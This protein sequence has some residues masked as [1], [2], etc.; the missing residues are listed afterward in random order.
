MIKKMKKKKMAYKN[1]ITG[2]YIITNIIDN[3]VYIG[4]S[5]NCSERIC[6]H[7][8]NLR[9][10]THANPHLQSSWSLYGEINFTFGILEECIKEDL[11]KAEDLWCIKLNAHDRNFGYNINPTG[12]GEKITK[13]KETIEKIRI[14]NTG[15]T[16]SDETKKKLSIINTGNIIT[17]ETIEKLK[18]SKKN[19][20]VD[21]Y[22]KIGNF[23]ATYKSLREAEREIGIS[24]KG[25]RLCLSSKY[26][27]TEGFIFKYHGEE[28]TIEEINRRNENCFGAKKTSVIGYTLDGVL[29]G[30]FDSYYQA[31]KQ[32][33][34]D[35]YK[36]SICC[37]G[38]QKR[39]KNIV[40][41]YLT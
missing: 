16:V 30:E 5:V 26:N 12:I 2:I 23:I 18:N 38:K 36:I 40:W 4:E 8:S 7:K 19:M 35:P 9:K 17:K 28:L 11:L 34:Q 31:G 13:S 14:A 20:E 6:K 3:K 15:K 32:T 24:L 21:Q 1:K 37:K 25:I 29:I 10:G 39:V 41:S 33:N 22:D 27:L